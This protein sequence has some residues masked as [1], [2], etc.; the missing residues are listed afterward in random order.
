MLL[1]ARGARATAGRESAGAKPHAEVRVRLAQRHGAD[2][3][4]ARGVT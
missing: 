1:Q 4:R 2:T 3:D